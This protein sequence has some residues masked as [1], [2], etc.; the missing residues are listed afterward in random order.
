M[1]DSKKSTREKAASARAAAEASERRRERTVRF[2]IFGVVALVVLGIIGAVLWTTRS[3]PAPTPENT[4]LPAGVAAPGYGAP[5]G[6]ATKP[7]LDVY[8]DFQC[9][10]CAAFEKAAGATV[11]ELVANGQ[12]KVVYHPMNF[13]DANLG[14]DS[15][16]RAAAAFGCAVDAGV[17]LKYHDIVYANQPAT[18]G[19]G[20]TDEQLKS[21]GQQAG[22]SGAQL[23]TFNACVDAKTYLGWPTLSNQAASE[24]GV[25]G[26]PALFLNGSKLSNEDIASAEAFKAKILAAAGQ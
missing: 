16:T 6:T 3:K 9:P 17:T 26:T 19:V 15:S 2:A 11:D 1:S 12:V 13:L 24:N 18:E 20:Y 7:V 22:L 23:D 5:V 14:N 4:A 21:F 8:E 25:T 10:A